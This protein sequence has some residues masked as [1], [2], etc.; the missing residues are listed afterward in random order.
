M[1]GP[2]GLGASRA[3]EKGA[4]RLA[5]AGVLERY[6]E[7]GKQAQRSPGA[8]IACFDRRVVRNAG[9]S[10]RKPRPTVFTNHESRIT[11]FLVLKVFFHR[12]VRAEPFLMFWSMAPT[13]ARSTGP[14]AFAVE[15]NMGFSRTRDTKHESR[16]FFETRNTNHGFFSKHETRLFF[17]TRLFPWLVWCTL[18]LKPFSLVFC[19]P[20]CLAS[21]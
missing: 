6:V 20:V 11:A 21:G 10:N 17:E 12:P 7:H 8:R 19:A 9:Y 16:L 4:S 14:P 18:V 1:R 3:E 5:R 15:P 2:S 13:K